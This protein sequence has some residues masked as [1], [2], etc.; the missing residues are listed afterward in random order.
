ML[1]GWGLEERRAQALRA[2]GQDCSK[3]SEAAHPPP[4]PGFRVWG[5]GFRV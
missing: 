3:D 1:L 4:P 2:Q 5:L